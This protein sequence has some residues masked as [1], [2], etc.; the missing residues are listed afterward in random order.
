[1]GP[2]RGTIEQLQKSEERYRRVFENAP[3]GICVAGLDGSIL[4]VNPALCRMVGYSEEE[5]L[6]TI[7]GELDHPEDSGPSLEELEQLLPDPSGWAEAEKRY[8][9]RNGSV[10]WGRIRASLAR[11]GE[12]KPLYFVVHAENITERKR[13][14][15]ALRESEE[16]FRIMADGCPTLMWVTNAEG[17]IQFINRACREFFGI[18]Y[19]EAEGGKWQLL[20]H[21]DDVPEYAERWQRAVH[22]HTAFKI[23]ARVRHA[24]GEW[25]WVATNAEPRFSSSGE[26]LGH[27]GLSPDIT[28]RKQAEQVLQFQNS[29]IRAIHEVSL[30][31]ILVVNDKSIVMSHNKRFLDILQISLPDIQNH[32]SGNVV[33]TPDQPLLSAF[34]DQVKDPEPFLRRVRELYNDQGAEDHCEIALK[35]GRTLQRYSTGLRSESGNYLG[36][37]WFFRDITARKQAGQDLRSSEEKFRR[38]AE[39]IDEVIWMVPQTADEKLYIS[40]AYEQ[41]WGRTCESLYQNP[42]SWM[43]AIHPD[44][45]EQSRLFVARQL[46]G[47]PTEREYRIRTPEGRE[48][49]IR[50]RAFPI[51]DEAGQLI[52]VVGI[53][54]DITQRKRYEA[55]LASTNHA[56]E[57]SEARYRKLVDLSP[58]AIIVGQNHATTLVNKAAVELFG[59]SSASELIGERFADLVNPES[60][61]TT[62]KLIQRMY[63]CEMQLPLQEGQ[64]R[65]KDGSLLDVEIAASS[66]GENGVR[67]VQAVLH[68]ITQRKQA[69][70]EHARLIRGIEQVGESIVITDLEGSIL[71]VN[72]AYEKITG[73]TRA[74]V[75]GRASLMTKS[76]RHPAAFYEAM[77]A[78]LSRGETWYGELINKRKDGTLFNE[79]ATISPIKNKDGK[80][81]NYVAVK[82][83]VTQETLLRDQLNQAQKMEAVGR[84]A[85]GIAHDFNNLLM[86]IQSYTEMLQDSLPAHDPLRRNTREVMKAAERGASLTGQMLAFSRKQITSPVVLDLNVV[87]DETAKMLKRIIGEDIEFRVESAE[88]LWAIKADP[89]QIGQVLMNLCVNSRDAL[90]K[91]GTLTIATGNV[92]VAEG[93]MGGHAGVSPGDY[94]RLS[95]TDTGMGISKKLQARIFEPFFTTK[96]VGK[97]TGLGLAMVYGIVQQSGG[98]VWVQSEPGRG[99]CFTIYL[100]RVREAITHEMSAIAEAQLRGTE[101]LLV[102]EDAEALREAICDYLRSLGYTVFAASSGQ[103]ALLVASQQGH[104]DLLL[105]DVVMPQMSG[106]ELSQMLGSLRPSLKTIYMSGYT[107]D[108]VLRHGILELGGHFLQKPFSLGTLAREI[109]DTLGLD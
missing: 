1:M 11:D 99:T 74:E 48:K 4:Q 76:D 83:D 14:E 25:R 96:E 71:Y 46:Q 8:I 24:N 3:F 98:R 18:T 57:T 64:I 36:R 28:D 31:G 81:I 95:V 6:A 21:P 37:V 67:V 45:Q 62:E 85:G 66:F 16:R 88:S 107:D 5:M 54:E 78:T 27:V 86:V 82:R 55:E 26:F 41:V 34:L 97:G 13:V 40:P 2:E 15:G 103:Q 43:E 102:A 79:E 108:A 91:G 90:P 60:R 92:T 84:L 61:G 30:D 68:N 38:F 109:S 50:D 23:E 87:I 9:H 70:E 51:R 75:I 53:S 42:M 39:N 58:N 52:R 7:W 35:D 93:S 22:E 77:W 63:E 100:P 33:G 47:E 19:E 20:V 59:V 80:V 17:G 65:R 44:D 32:F 89:D 105:T 69:E 106:R 94:V 49:W 73:Y 72:P 101:T 104:I 29:L 56:W 12:G 10:V